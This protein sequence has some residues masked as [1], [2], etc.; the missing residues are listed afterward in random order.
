MFPEIEKI[1][2]RD[3]LNITLNVLKKYGVKPREK[4]SQNFIIDPE[5]IKLILDQV[6]RDSI[7]LEIGTGIGT[8][9]YYLALKA[10]KVYTVEIDRKLIRV[11]SD[12]LRDYKNVEIVQG[13]AL[14]INWPEVDYL[15]SN[16]PYHI[17]SPLI[18][19]MIK[20]GIPNAVIT[21]QLEVGERLLAKA[22]SESY[23]R[24]SIITQ[25]A[26]IIE[27]LRKV[28]PESFY[29]SP[30]VS[31]IILKL[32]CREEKCIE[33]LELLE[34]MTNILFRH[35]NRSIKW[36]VS[37]Y[38]GN[39][40]LNYITSKNFNVN[41]RVRDLDLESIVKL[42]NYCIECEVNLQ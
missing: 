8:L 35:R 26:Y 1:S 15:V 18:I 40:F 4:L 33:D 39:E 32:R 23:G 31:S 24:L 13:D 16:L 9:T 42:I 34:K 27:R 14:K 12:V 22:G 5:V 2:R 3:L 28:G 36:V 21:V 6:P 11:A 10:H 38:F 25:C 30:E 20:Y 29:P 41:A 7:I 17:T 19:K 37:K